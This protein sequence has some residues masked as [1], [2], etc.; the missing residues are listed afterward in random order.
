[1][2]HTA[3]IPGDVPTSE[4][5]G[6]PTDPESILQAQD[7]QEALRS[8][9]PERFASDGKAIDTTTPSTFERC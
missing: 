6:K 5:P 2:P 1:M 9:R 4:Q 8:L 3:A 7:Y